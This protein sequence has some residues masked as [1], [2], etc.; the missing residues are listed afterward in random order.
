MMHKNS[1]IIDKQIIKQY[2]INNNAVEIYFGV[3][4]TVPC[5][6]SKCFIS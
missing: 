2:I 5:N 1:T 3:P 6:F 4:H